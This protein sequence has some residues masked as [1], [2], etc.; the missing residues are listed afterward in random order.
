MYGLPYDLAPERVDIGVQLFWSPL[1]LVTR[2][3]VADRIRPVIATLKA[4]YG[5]EAD[6]GFQQVIRKPQAEQDAFGFLVLLQEIVDDFGLD[7]ESEAKETA[8]GR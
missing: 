8:D 2:R 3:K 1:G 7:E 6:G 4:K 5:F